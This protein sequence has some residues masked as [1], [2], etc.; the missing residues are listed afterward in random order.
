MIERCNLF[1]GGGEEVRGELVD[2]PGLL[3]GG[4]VRCLS[5]SCFSLRFGRQSSVCLL[6]LGLSLLFGGR[7]RGAS[8]GWGSGWLLCCAEESTCTCLCLG[9]VERVV[10]MRGVSAGGA[11]CLTLL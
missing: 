3:I 6:G 11:Y 8:S 1:V 10:P 5:W 7:G 2:A 4:L 9:K